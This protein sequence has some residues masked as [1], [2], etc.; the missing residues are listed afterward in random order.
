MPLHPAHLL[1]DRACDL[2]L[3]AQEMRRCSGKPGIA[4]A[5]PATLGCIGAV[6]EELAVSATGL[7]EELGR[8][9]ALADPVLEA[10]ERVIEHLLLAAAECDVARETTGSRLAQECPGLR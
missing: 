8:T 9:E 4:E 5:I 6:A 10:L 2:L 7:A 1:Y 3:A